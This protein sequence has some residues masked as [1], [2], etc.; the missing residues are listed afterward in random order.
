MV[1]NNASMWGLL[2]IHNTFVT[3]EKKQYFGF[4]V[5]LIYRFGHGEEGISVVMTAA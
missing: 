5:H 2:M 4:A 3:E 1:V